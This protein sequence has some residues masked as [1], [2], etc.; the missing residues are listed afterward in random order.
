MA[1]P[2]NPRS[3]GFDVALANIDAAITAAF[4][5]TGIP[6][7]KVRAACVALAGADREAERAQIAAW[8]AER[9]I[10]ERVVLTNDADPILAAASPDNWG[11]ALIA[12]TGSFAFGRNRAGVSAR[13]GGWGY[14]FGDEGSGYATALAGLR[15]AARAADGRSEP[16]QLL[17]LLQTRLQVS[18][19]QDLI[20][21]IYRP[22]MQRRQIADL[23]EVVLTAWQLGDAAAREIVTAAAADLAQLVQTLA[24]KLQLPA[25]KFPLAMAG[26]ILLNYPALRSAV[27][28]NLANTPAAPGPVTLVPEPVRGAVILARQALM[29]PQLD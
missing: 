2:G 7:L 18:T 6:R 19:P 29:P 28:N 26:G 21:A 22:E 3:A 1:G 8:C 4:T 9:A 16:T 5:D 13:C 15:A 24:N 17:T 23:A 27:E 12:G 14:L 25:G 11:I 20:G 10:A